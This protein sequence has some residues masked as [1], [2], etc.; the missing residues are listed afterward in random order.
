MPLLYFV[1]LLMVYPELRQRQQ[2][3][4]KS[5]ERAMMRRPMTKVSKAQRLL[6]LGSSSRLLA[7]TAAGRRS[8]K[9]RTS[10]GRKL[11]TKVSQELHLMEALQFLWEDYEVG[12][13]HPASPS[14][15]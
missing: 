13:L 8:H 14:L 9:S 11:A 15:A 10:Q 12:R 1:L 7:A 2:R 5:T 3:E 6:G 4:L